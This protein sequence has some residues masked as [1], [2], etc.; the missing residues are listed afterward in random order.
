L[1]LW[2]LS[3]L[4]LLANEIAQPFR[5]AFL[6]QQALPPQALAGLSKGIQEKFAI[7]IIP[8][9]RFAFVSA[10]RDK[11]NGDFYSTHVR[12]TACRF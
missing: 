9:D 2:Y 7:A 4:L 10:Q 12:L 1:S 8:E 6:S 5:K 11:Q 3:D